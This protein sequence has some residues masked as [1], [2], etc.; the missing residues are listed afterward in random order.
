MATCLSHRVISSLPKP[1][2]ENCFFVYLIA[3]HAFLYTF[4]TFPL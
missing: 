3:A 2:L 1:E 4:S